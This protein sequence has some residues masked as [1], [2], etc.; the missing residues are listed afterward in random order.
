VLNRF[1]RRYRI[2]EAIHW[3]LHDGSLAWKLTKAADREALAEIGPQ[4]DEVDTEAKIE[5]PGEWFVVSF[6]W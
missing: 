3:E 6:E 2:N 5:V 1:E 4:F